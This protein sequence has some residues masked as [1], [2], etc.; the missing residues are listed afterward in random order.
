[1]ILFAIDNQFHHYSSA[2]IAEMVVG[3]STFRHRMK[4]LV[5]DISKTIRFDPLWFIV[6][7]EAIDRL[8]THKTNFPKK[9]IEIK[10]N[11]KLGIVYYHYYFT[12]NG[13]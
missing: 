8:W 10:K 1:L 3:Y 13:G 11:G 7:F 6:A 4:S 5:A 2:R 12:R 9:K